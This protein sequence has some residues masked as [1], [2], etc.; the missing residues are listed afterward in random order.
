MEL[1]LL[2]AQAIP[3][4]PQEACKEFNLLMEDKS[5]DCNSFFNEKPFL[6]C[7]GKTEFVYPTV[8][9]EVEFLTD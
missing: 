6:S 2:R 7:A 1:Y 8:T 5:P 3:L 4:S 9:C